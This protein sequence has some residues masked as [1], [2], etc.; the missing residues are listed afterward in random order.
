MVD[1]FSDG[2]GFIATSFVRK[3]RGARWFT[4]LFLCLN[5]REPETNDGKV[6]PQN[7]RLA[8]F[9]SIEI[10]TRT[11]DDRTDEPIRTTAQLSS[12]TPP[13]STFITRSAH[14]IERTLFDLLE[15]KI[16]T[17]SLA[18]ESGSRTQT[19]TT[20]GFLPK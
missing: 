14:C 9:N 10:I 5:D 2:V 4:P 15:Q 11:A 17:W 8:R 19:E 7:L 3:A 12:T 1:V 16:E 18:R 13:P 6:C 20:L